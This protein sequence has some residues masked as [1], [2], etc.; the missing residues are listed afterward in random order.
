LKQIALAF[1]GNADSASTIEQN[2]K[3]IATAPVLGDLPDKIYFSISEEI[4]V[5][6]QSSWKPEDLISGYGRRGTEQ[7]TR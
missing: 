7:E 4:R 3:Q 1:R 2:Q 5:P 6:E